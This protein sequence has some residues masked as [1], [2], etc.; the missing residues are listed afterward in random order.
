MLEHLLLHLLKAKIGWI[1]MA[2]I[3]VIAALLVLGTTGFVVTG[4]IQGD[5]DD[6][7]VNLTIKPLETKKCVD[8]LIAQTE[9][10]LEL[11][12]L[13]ADATRQ[14]RHLRE[15]ARESADDQNKLLDEAALRAQFDLSSTQIRDALSSARQDVFNVKN[16]D[17]CQDGNPDTTVDLDIADLRARYDKI[18]RDFGLKVSSVL[19]DAQNAFDVLVQNAPPKPPKQAS[20]SS[21]SRD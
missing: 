15:N 2:K 19:T 6:K 3:P 17:K 18:L 12:V 21:R 4:T 1:T 14:L 9:T 13:A 10:L 5:D 11:D 7:I 20:Q 16:L 8:A